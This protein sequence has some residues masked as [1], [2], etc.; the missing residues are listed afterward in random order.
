MPKGVKYG[1][2][3]EETIER[4][5][6]SLRNGDTGLNSASRTYSVPKTTLKGCLVGKNDYAVEGKEV[7]GNSIDLPPKVKEEI[8][9]LALKLEQYM[10]GLTPTGLPS[11]AYQV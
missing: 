7:I 1:R 8:R 11:L 3:E 6:S 2:W 9:N 10:F 5:L 4:A